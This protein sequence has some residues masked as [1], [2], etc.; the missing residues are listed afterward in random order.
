MA[1]VGVPAAAQHAQLN[2]HGIAIMNPTALQQ[3][4][5]GVEAGVIP[6]NA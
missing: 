6:E 1:L 5:T 4:E 3:G 2:N